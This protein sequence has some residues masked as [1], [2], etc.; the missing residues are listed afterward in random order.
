MCFHCYILLWPCLKASAHRQ[1]IG[2]LLESVNGRG[3]C[4][5]DKINPNRLH[6]LIK[7]NPHQP[8][9]IL[10]VNSSTLSYNQSDHLLEFYDVLEMFTLRCLEKF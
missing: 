5:T 10:Q 2:F 9:V 8:S 3:Y 4:L 6:I 7:I 1:K